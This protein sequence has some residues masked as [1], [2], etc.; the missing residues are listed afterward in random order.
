MALIAVLSL[1][2]YLHLRYL[3]GT[4]PICRNN[5]IDMLF[6]SPK[7]RP[8]CY[9]GDVCVRHVPCLKR[10]PRTS[11]DHSFHRQRSGQVTCLEAMATRPLITFLQFFMRCLAEYAI[12]VYLTSTV[13]ELRL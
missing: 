7:M 6:T 13:L 10:N 12:F 1:S 5:F 3:S 9:G 8:S 4:I 11:F 2:L